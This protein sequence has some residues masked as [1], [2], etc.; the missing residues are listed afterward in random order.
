MKRYLMLV[1]VMLAFIGVAG[2][3]LYISGSYNDYSEHLRAIGAAPGAPNAM[4]LDAKWAFSRLVGVGIIFGGLIWGS[5]LL[6]LGWA[7]QVL[8]EIRDSLLVEPAP[9]A[10]HDS[11]HTAH[12]RS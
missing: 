8:E 11:A 6:G 1:G 9:E 10:A 2:G 5:V 3:S 4:F 12:A 7:I